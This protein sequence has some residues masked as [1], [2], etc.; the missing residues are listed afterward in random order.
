MSISHHNLALGEEPCV[1]SWGE[2]V[3][4][5]RNLVGYIIETL[6]GWSAFCDRVGFVG[7]FQRKYEAIA[8][9]NG[10]AAR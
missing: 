9:L 3:V 2:R 6:E 5:D 1:K 8:A 4:V 7:V 10:R